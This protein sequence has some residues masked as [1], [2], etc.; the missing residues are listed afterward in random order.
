MNSHMVNIDVDPSL[1]N[2]LK[3][4]NDSVLVLHFW[5]N[6]QA[7]KSRQINDVVD[8]AIKTK[9]APIECVLIDVEKYKGIA[10]RYKIETIPTSVIICKEL[11]YGRVDGCDDSRLMKLMKEAGFKNFP[12]QIKKFPK[13][14]LLANLT[15]SEDIS[16]DTLLFLCCSNVPEDD[17]RGDAI[18]FNLL[19]NSLNFTPVESSGGDK[20][21]NLMKQFIFD[22][23]H[24]DR[25]FISIAT[26]SQNAFQADRDAF[27]I[28][29]LKF[30]SIIANKYGLKTPPS[31]LPKNFFTRILSTIMST[32][33]TIN[34]RLE[35]GQSS[36]FEYFARIIGKIAAQ[37]YSDIVYDLIT[38]LICQNSA[39]NFIWRRMGSKM[40]EVQSARCLESLL[41]PLLYHSP[42][43]DHIKRIMG[44]LPIRKPEVRYLMT[45]KFT[46]IVF[47]DKPCFLDN[48][49]G[50]LA[51]I[52]NDLVVESMKNLVG[53]WC[54]ERA[55]R[56]RYYAHHFHICSGLIFVCRLLDT[57]KIDS[58][59][60]D[61]MIQKVIGG[62]EIYLKNAEIEL[63][64]TGLY[65]GQVILALFEKGEL[66]L[67]L[68]ITET[69]EVL[70]LKRLHEG[71][72][73]HDLSRVSEDGEIQSAQDLGSFRSVQEHDRQC[74]DKSN[75]IEPQVNANEEKPSTNR[76]PKYI[77]DCINGLLESDNPDWRNACLENACELI[78]K[79]GPMTEDYA[80]DL[81]RALLF[82]DDDFF[83]SNF[84]KDRREAM[85]AL[86]VSCPV[87]SA[88]YLT[89]CF[90][91]RNVVLQ[92]RLDILVILAASSVELAKSTPSQSLPG[93]SSK[94]SQD[95]FAEKWW[96]RVVK[97]RIEQK[98]KV[99]P[100]SSQPKSHINTFAKVAP[101]FFFPLMKN[102]FNTPI[103][104]MTDDYFLLARLLYTLG[105]VLDSASQAFISRK[106][107]LSLIEFLW[108]VRY[109]VES[110]VRKAIIFCF[111]VILTA[112]PPVFLME[113]MHHEIVEFQK[114]LIE[115]VNKDC[116]RE[117]V[118]RALLALDI[119]RD[120][121]DSQ[122]RP[123]EFSFTP[124]IRK[125]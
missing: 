62:I 101:Y 61:E 73:I 12:S 36:Q 34:D 64:L 120:I 20:L 94:N 97:E 51:S 38:R 7:Q 50:Y 80:E 103:N 14:E 93:S 33:I 77:V 41:R 49:I 116:D 17:G 66:H 16:W 26:D 6:F 86:T 95:L 32:L 124:L 30:P 96:E 59:T 111:C 48:L 88:N 43:H 106:M 107:G 24:L 25:S 3:K 115:V 118:T 58:Q 85:I 1:E 11:E 108:A 35:R 114:W 42:N 79:N 8:E 121:S 117:C 75:D 119:L 15:S 91:D 70:K 69:S 29:L 122:Q 109:H 123:N 112:V 83:T 63:R 28:S 21:L 82:L 23:S 98:T 71:G 125:G 39:D 10:G 9:V 102:D 19:I 5:A 57:G 37:G 67:D 76:K 78:R 13:E 31:F 52:S 60:C 87:S 90:F 40:M 100:S 44:D 53:A 92:R 47:F 84:E 72:C 89:K 110:F 46:T 18:V 45:K 54:N 27:A 81:A 4:S 65:A 74:K 2:H 56:T 55:L 68:E 104:L 105:I 113:N 99:F 22:G